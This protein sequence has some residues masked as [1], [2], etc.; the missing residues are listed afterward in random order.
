MRADRRVDTAR[1]IELVRADH[2]II[3]R[4]AHPVQ[5]LE[6]VARIAGERVDRGD[7]KR[8]VRRE[9]RIDDVGCSEHR[10][11]AGEIGD[12]GV[13][14]ARE[15]R[16]AG[17]AVDLRALDLAVPVR[18]LDEPQHQPAF[19]PP[20]QRD[21]PVDRRPRALLV[22]LDHEPETV[23]AGKIGIAREA[24]EEIQR[25]IEAVGFL[26]VDVE[27]DAVPFRTPGQSRNAWPQLGL[28]TVALCAAVA[29]M[30]RRELD[31]DAGTR[32]D[33]AT[34]RNVSDRIDR[35]LVV[36]DVALC[37]DGSQRCLPKHVERERV[38]AR[39]AFARIGERLVDRPARYELAPEQSHREVDALADQRLAALAQERAERLLQR[40]LAARVDELAGYQQSPRRGVDKQRRR[41][42]DVRSPVAAGD[43][44]ADQPVARRRIGDAQQRLGETHQRNALAAVERELE[45]QRVDAAGRRALGPDGFGKRQ[46]ELLRCVERSRCETCLI[47]QRT[48]R[49]GFIGAIGLRDPAPE[50]GK[51]RI[52]GRAIPGE[53]E[54]EC[55]TGVGRGDHDRRQ[56]SA[57]PQSGSTQ[58]S[59]SSSGERPRTGSPRP[60]HG[61]CG[62]PLPEGVR[63]GCRLASAQA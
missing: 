51:V 34:R 30:Q 15:H 8:V 28:D 40:A 53:A 12:V 10:L 11:R 20:R 27:A 62:C 13:P 46:R 33:A 44:V 55:G 42:A 63:A 45:H 35:P 26:G 41:Y 59:D 54:V 48:H 21:E 9:L 2:V 25:K 18:T 61:R 52:R 43:L 23:P 39:L 57:A 50:W 32:G 22:A 3:D 5:A 56:A 17:E 24:L 37:I 16:I 60:G 4:F 47:D 29:W 36:V 14:L 6:F 38:A 1:A 19:F 49:R 58:A 7:R 31:R